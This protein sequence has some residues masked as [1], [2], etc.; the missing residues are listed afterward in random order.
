MMAARSRAARQTEA[1]KKETTAKETAARKKLQR[2]GRRLI[3][4]K[5][6]R[7]ASPSPACC[8]LASVP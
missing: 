8:L 3:L 1:L 2:K 6:V 5:S 7:P 4:L